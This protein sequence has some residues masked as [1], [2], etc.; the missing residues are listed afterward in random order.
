MV[1]FADHELP[2]VA[3]SYILTG[4]F[5]PEHEF[6]QRPAVEKNSARPG[7][8]MAVS[9]QERTWAVGTSEEWKEYRRAFDS[10]V[11]EDLRDEVIHDRKDLDR[12]FKHLDQ[13]GTPLVDE[14]GASW[15]QISENGESYKVGLSAGNVLAQDSDPQ[16]AREFLLARI[17]HVLKSPKHSRETMLEFRQDWAALQRASTRRPMILARN[18]TP[19]KGRR[20][21]S[22]S[23]DGD[24]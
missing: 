4:R 24:D 18:L 23:N 22:L 19:A 15:M 5:N 3:A 14:D 17:N 8:L 2:A 16:L 20:E 6:E 1:I 13:A 10:I 9:P 7:P 11:R 21:T 12:F